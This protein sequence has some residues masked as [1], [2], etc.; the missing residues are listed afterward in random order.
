MNTLPVV[1]VTS[2]ATRKSILDAIEQKNWHAAQTLCK[3]ALKQHNQAERVPEWWHLAGYVAGQMGD[4]DTAIGHMQKAVQMAPD[5]S[6][7][8]YN[9]AV[10]L[11]EVGTEKSKAQAALHYQACLRHQPNHTDALWNYG[12]MLRLGEHFA[13]AKEKFEHFL[14]LGGNYPAI[15]HRLAVTYAALNQFNPAKRH[16][17]LAFASHEATKK[18]TDTQTQTQKK[19][20]DHGMTHWECALFMLSNAEF[21]QGFAHYQYRFECQGRNNVVC[22]GFNLPLWQG[23][24]TANSTLLIHG[25]QGLGD[26]MMFAS[27]LPEVLHQANQPH[28][29]MCV[30]LAVKPPLVQL[31]LDSFSH[32]L[33]WKA[34]AFQVVSHRV[35]QFWDLNWDSNQKS[36]FHHR[37]C[38]QLPIGDLAVLFRGDAKQFTN[39]QKRYLLPNA[40]CSTFQ[41]KALMQQLAKKQPRVL[42]VGLMW[43]SNPTQNVSSQFSRWGL[44]RSIPLNLFEIFFETL[45]EKERESICHFVQFVGLQNHERGFEASAAPSL[46]I[47]DLSHFQTDFANTAGLIANL[48]L[49]IS[50]DTSVAHLAGGMGVETWVLLMHRSDWRHFS[51]GQRREKSL[52]YGNTRY[53]HQTQPQQ[54]MQVVQAVFGALLE[55]IQATQNALQHDS[56]SSADVHLN[57]AKKHF[58]NR[59]FANATVCFERALS[60]STSGLDGSSATVK[61]QWEYAMLLLTQGLSPAETFPSLSALDLDNALKKGWDMHEMRHVIF[62]WE[63][64]HLCPLHR[65]YPTWQG[66]AITGKTVLL[67]GEQGLGDEIMALSLLPDVL[68]RVENGKVILACHPTLVEWVRFNFPAVLVFGHSRGK[69]EVWL[70][71]LPNWI[72]GLSGVDCQISLS[73]LYKFL[74]TTA[75]SFQHPITSWQADPV[76]IAK[77]ATNLQAQV[78]EHRS[79]QA[80]RFGTSTS[81]NVGARTVHKNRP[82][83]IG[84]AWHGS[85]SNVNARN[86]STLLQQW[87]PL[88]DWAETQGN[89]QIIGLHSHEYT[90]QSTLLNPTAKSLDNKTVDMGAFTADF[91]DLAALVV[92]LDW[93]IGV[94]TSF[95]HLSSALGVPTWRLLIR[96]CDWRWGWQGENSKW[97]QNDRLFRQTTDGDWDGVIAKII[98]ACQAEAEAEQHAGSTPFKPQKKQANH[99]NHRVHASQEVLSISTEH[100]P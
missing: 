40:D 22:H 68:Q 26:E 86:R 5:Y 73:S 75:A 63:A 18:C 49:V 78:T 90:P 52:W 34:G 10:T 60:E 98:S 61:I 50:V 21:A 42:K 17:E 95:T 77:M 23:Q 62:G 84:L 65:I 82:I 72:D 27:I 79:R 80:S 54:W 81:V 87:Q 35:G 3:F 25:E 57:W 66:E 74:R 96:T 58:Q 69:P 59:D 48:D 53:F 89:I 56:N 100:E 67:H 51:A 41:K 85:L 14:E 83:R 55:K 97:Y 4:I 37:D 33:N 24:F 15:H 88:F 9:L 45:T 94:D 99:K 39:A 2:N 70:R 8:H 38:H 43:G 13:L 91:A 64:L 29:Q 31:F 46:D 47:V 93:V 1:T 16:F 30:I 7:C 76:R 20:S 44:Q 92:Q 28:V 12:E 6:Q 19:T 36:P 32:L 71:T 11:C